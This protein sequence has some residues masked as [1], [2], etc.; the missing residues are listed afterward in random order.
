MSILPPF[1]NKNALTDSNVLGTLEKWAIF[2]EAKEKS[3]NG[4]LTRSA[5]E[6]TLAVVDSSQPTST[7]L[8]NALP[9]DDA[10]TEKAL[11]EMEEPL[12]LVKLN[13]VVTRKEGTG[14]DEN[15]EESAV[16]DPGASATV[17]PEEEALVRKMATDLLE[18]WRD[19][20]VCV[21]S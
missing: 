9:V 2:T 6:N 21:L 3:I 13:G 10:L 11:L 14:V 5:S 16:V 12:A 18:G 4:P 20:A 7:E 15:E 8:E 19:L 1:R 17:R